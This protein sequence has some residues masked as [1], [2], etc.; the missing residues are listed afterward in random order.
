M[1]AEQILPKGKLGMTEQAEKR[2]I[3]IRKILKT[4]L[5]VFDQAEIR[6]SQPKILCGH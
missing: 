2:R 1:L 4:K 3:E 6:E 5:I